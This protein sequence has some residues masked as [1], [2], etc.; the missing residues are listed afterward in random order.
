MATKQSR[1]V[2]IF[3][4]PI[5]F[6][7]LP[8]RN[9]L[10]YRNFDFKRLNKINLSTLFTILVTFSLETPDFTL[11]T[12]TPFTA[13][14]QKSAYHVKYLRMSWIYLDLL[15]RFGSRIGGD[16]YTDIRLAVA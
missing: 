12:I 1:K 6:V 8:F 2:G 16:D 5:Y 14:Q 4:G 3:R 13:I 11:L 10:Q 7:V 15:Y 9:G